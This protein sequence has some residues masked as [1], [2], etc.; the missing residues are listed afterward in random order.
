MSLNSATLLRKNGPA[1]T[2]ERG[3]SEKARWFVRGKGAEFSEY[4]QLHNLAKTINVNVC[5]SCNTSGTDPHC[6]TVLKTSCIGCRR[7]WLR[8]GIDPR[9]G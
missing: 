2:P 1:E 5:K 6:F 3:T 8:L 9:I 7:L 4:L